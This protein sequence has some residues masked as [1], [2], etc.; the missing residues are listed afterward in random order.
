MMPVQKTSSAIPI[1]AWIIAAVV[2]LLAFAAMGLVTILPMGHLAW[3]F[4]IAP[5]LVASA[6]GA[7]ALGAGYVYGDARRRGMRHVMWT[8]LV[9]F[10]P[11]A[12][13]FILYFMM[14]DPMPVF[15]PRCGRGM[16]PG[17]AF[18][19]SCGN[20]VAPACA[21]CGKRLEAGWTHCAWCGS[22]TS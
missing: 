18:C 15:C 17:F 2:F 13:G 6:A 12:I 4:V 5:L 14:R 7:Y 21:S 8:L 20:N 11:N 10:V 22:K 1:G 16:N 19:P 9:I 3:P